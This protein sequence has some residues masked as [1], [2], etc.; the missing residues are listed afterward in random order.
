MYMQYI[1]PYITNYI[2]YNY[3]IKVKGP[4]MDDPYRAERWSKKMY[5]YDEPVRRGSDKTWRIVGTVIFWIVV[6]GIFLYFFY[7]EQK[8]LGCYV[9]RQKECTSHFYRVGPEEGDDNLTLLQRME[10]FIRQQEETVQWRKTLLISIV[11]AVALSI[12][13]VRDWPSPGYFIVAVAIV[14][15]LLFSVFN[16]YD[17]HYWYRTRED[18][19]R[20]VDQLR[21]NLG[22][23]KET[24]TCGVLGP[25]ETRGI[26]RQTCDTVKSEF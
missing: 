20:T 22:Y 1:D 17:M 11:I 5:W 24:T 16:W 6:L 9:K 26:T 25:M 13:F 4:R 12:L 7:I 19:R 23:M 18:S 8:H 21:V 14:Y 10:N 2:L 3:Y 15:V